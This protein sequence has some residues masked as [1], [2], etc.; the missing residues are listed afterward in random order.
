MHCCIYFTMI[1]VHAQKQATSHFYIHSGT[2]IQTEAALLGVELY[3]SH[4]IKVKN[5]AT[6]SR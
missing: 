2:N 1:F 6:F 4:H 5:L 3:I